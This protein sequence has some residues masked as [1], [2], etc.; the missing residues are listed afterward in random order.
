MYI[1]NDDTQKITPSVDYKLW[2]KCSDTQLYEPTYQNSIK[3]PK[4]DKL[5]N[6]KTF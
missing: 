3:G 2:L 6:K 4:F 5:T 1:S